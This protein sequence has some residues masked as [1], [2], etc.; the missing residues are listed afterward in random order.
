M[1]DAQAHSLKWAISLGFVWLLV[2]F[3]LG[4]VIRSMAGRV[5]V[6]RQMSSTELVSNEQK[7]SRRKA[8]FEAIFN[9]IT[10][11]VVFIDNRKRIVMVNPAFTELTGYTFEE[12]KGRES[13]LLFTH[14]DAFLNNM[15]GLSQTVC[16]MECRLKD[17]SVIPTEILGTHVHDSDGA[18]IGY[19]M[20]LRD[21]TPR[22]AAE[23]E[24]SKIAF[25]L[26]QS[27][28]MEAIGT[29]AG[30]IAHDFNNILGIIFVNTDMALEDIPEGNPARKNIQR[31]VQASTRA[32]NLVKQI[33]AYSRQA[34]Q[35]LIQLMPGSLI[36]EALQF[37][38]STTPASVTIV[39]HINDGFR[40]IMMDPA[41]LQQLLVNLFSNAVRAIDDRGTVEVNGTIVELD[42]NDVAGRQN[43]QP[44]NYF[45]LSVS[46]TGDG[47]GRA[48][49]ERMYTT[50]E[51]SEDTNMGLATVMG[52]VRNHGGHITVDS[53]PGSGTIVQVFF[54]VVALE[55]SQEESDEFLQGT[56]RVLFIDDEYMLIE[57]A[58]MF[59][60]N[61][62]FRV[63][64]ETDSLEALEI[65]RSRPDEFD[66]VVTDQTM[67]EMTGS[68]LAVELFKIRPDVPVILLS[69]YSKKISE[70]E[71][72]ELGIR[73]FLYKPFD[74][75]TLVRSIR[76]V[77]D[78]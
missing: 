2:F 15:G 24:H 42:E 1:A 11:A 73:E 12:A 75:K 53:E 40:T 47:M 68:E 34:D 67:P 22:K 30:G 56:E 70:E 28:K 44:G 27:S 55:E 50:R 37:L 48:T 29:L 51:V 65:F 46:D 3:F 59:L 4:L 6:L 57:M 64:E 8:L 77:L 20:V 69:G 54:P 7:S 41:Q 60:Q 26:R 52:I 74:G 31:I 21:I 62:G 32:R 72:K 10:D 18:I 76:K 23:K 9:S 5:Q 39:Q 61:Q 17:G 16:E 36:K 43:I 25:K 19:H 66:I 78:E 35:E 49:Q 45:R 71:V 58:S 33:L 13:L 38:R 63:T 14:P